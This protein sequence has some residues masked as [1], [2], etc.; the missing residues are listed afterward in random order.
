MWLADSMVTECQAHVRFVY[1]GCCLPRTALS[2][3]RPRWRGDFG[4]LTPAELCSLRED[5]GVGIRC[6]MG[7]GCRGSGEH[8]IE[9]Y[10][11]HHFALLLF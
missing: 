5:L 1:R 9:Q 8:R 3:G 10:P 7:L 6:V 2:R 11:W 4:Q